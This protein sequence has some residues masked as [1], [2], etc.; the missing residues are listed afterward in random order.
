[1]WYEV[2]EVLCLPEDNVDW[3][4]VDESSLKTESFH[5]VSF[6][7]TGRTG[8]CH[9]TTSGSTRDDKFIIMMISYCICSIIKNESATCQL[10]MYLIVYDARAIIQN[11][12]SYRI[13]IISD[14]LATVSVFIEHCTTDSISTWLFSLMKM[15]IE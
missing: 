1:M 10:C 5:D 9:T 7:I 4:F 6:T 13:S 3:Y 15:I 2:E 14:V 12:V 8:G 11:L